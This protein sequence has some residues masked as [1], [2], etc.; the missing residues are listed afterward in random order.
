MRQN[1]LRFV[2]ILTVAIA[3]SFSAGFVSGHHA[4]RI[5]QIFDRFKSVYASNEKSIPSP[6][7]NGRQLFPPDDPWNTDVSQEPID[8]NSDALIASIGLSKSIHPDF[9]T[10]YNEAP[11]GIP[12]AVV[13]GNQPKVAVKF[14][15]KDESDRG[16]YPIP[17]DAQIEGGPNSDG[18]RHVL[19]IDKDNWILYELFGAV[20]GNGGTEWSAG[21]GAIFDLK[22]KS[23]QRPIGW[24]SADAAGLPMLAGLARYDEIVEQR[25]LTHALRFSVQHTR[26]A[27]VYP[28]SHFASSN[29]DANLPPMG[30]RVRLKADYD[31]SRFPPE[32]RVILQG[33]KTY[34]MIVADN[35]GNW[36]LSGAPDSRWSYS[37]IET[38]K[39]V[40]GSDFEV[41]RMGKIETK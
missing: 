31:I 21:S 40:K 2:T 30:M 25:K 23:T 41:V 37:Q 33:L 15:Y 18:D 4:H 22:K 17:A 16:P 20:P 13:P 27:F 8:P 9:G 24:T 5:K 35:G 19:I 14:T 26:R 7:L 36:F 29:T 1:Q 11:F 10:T 39:R 38:L 3:V 34:G 6:S 32:A 12:Y 28:A